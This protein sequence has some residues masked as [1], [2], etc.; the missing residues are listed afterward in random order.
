MPHDKH[1]HPG[2]HPTRDFSKIYCKV[3]DKVRPQLLGNFRDLAN[4]DK[5]HTVLLQKQSD[6]PQL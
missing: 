4:G 6:I 5:P 3:L 2:H 1:F